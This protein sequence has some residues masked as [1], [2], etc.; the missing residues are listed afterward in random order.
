[1]YDIVIYCNILKIVLFKKEICF[2]FFIS[3]RLRNCI[4]LNKTYFFV[5][6]I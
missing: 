2:S 4:Y 5:C 6:I 1:M 3:H